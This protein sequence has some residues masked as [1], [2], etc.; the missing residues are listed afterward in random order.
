MKKSGIVLVCVS[1][2]LILSLSTVSAGVFE[3]VSYWFSKIFGMSGEV[4][5]GEVFLN[6]NLIE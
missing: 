1:L 5:G 3:D 2:V 6:Q 4:V